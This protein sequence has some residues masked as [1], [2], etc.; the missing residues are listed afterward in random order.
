MSDQTDGYG[1]LT[2]PLVVGFYK[3]PCANVRRIIK[4][5][6][7]ILGYGVKT[8]RYFTIMAFAGKVA[9]WQSR[10]LAVIRLDVSSGPDG[11]SSR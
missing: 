1:R 11:V 6:L 3:A 10:S 9:K 7:D 2:G 4:G 5:G 8:K